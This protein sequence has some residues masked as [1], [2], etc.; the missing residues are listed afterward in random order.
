MSSKVLTWFQKYYLGNSNLHDS[1]LHLTIV[2]ECLSARQL[3]GCSENRLQQ[4]LISFIVLLCAL[5]FGSDLVP[6]YAPMF[7]LN[8]TMLG[9][10][11]SDSA[12]ILNLCIIV[13]CTETLLGIW[14]NQSYYNLD[15]SI[16]S[17]VWCY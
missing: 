11:W 13:W 7:L 1:S 10:E 3:A 2:D 16:C 17:Y 14:L 8:S 6:D 12:K 4:L 9:R 15:I 5:Q